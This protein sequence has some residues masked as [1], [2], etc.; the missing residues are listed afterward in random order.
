M[1]F[2]L[3]FLLI[4]EIWE[5]KFLERSWARMDGSEWERTTP[6]SQ[7]GI[8]GSR[9]EGRGSVGTGAKKR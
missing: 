9:R 6:E 7:E 5:C 2:R 8:E 4:R 1:S 3:T